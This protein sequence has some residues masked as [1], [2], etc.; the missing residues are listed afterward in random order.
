MIIKIL[1]IV[2]RGAGKMEFMIAELLLLVFGVENN[3]GNYILFEICLI[4]R[5][6]HVPWSPSV[7]RHLLFPYLT[8]FAALLTS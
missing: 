5:L 7:C 8:L 6:I 1:F 2:N 3:N 4:S